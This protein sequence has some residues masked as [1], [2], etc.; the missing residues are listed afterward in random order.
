MGSSEERIFFKDRESR[1]LTVSVGWLRAYRHGGPLEDVLGKTD[2]DIFSTPHAVEAFEDEQRIILTGQPMVAKLQR[3]T[4]HDRADE[5]T[6]TTK[7]PLLSPTGEIIGTFGIARDVT[8]QVEAQQ[9]LNF[10]ALHDSVTG[11]VNRVALMDRLSQALVSL[12]SPD[13]LV[14]LFVNLDDFKS[15]NDAL[16]HG[17]GDRVLREVGRRLDRISRRGDT[18]ARL[19]ADEFVLL[20][21]A[22]REGDDLA[23]ICDRAMRAICAP[24]QDGSHDLTVTASLGAVITSDSSAEPEELLQQADVAMNVFFFIVW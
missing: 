2:F 24:L 1:F 22:A 4:F 14:L 17:T 13:R 19:G 20:C 18:V 23:L 8:A 12:E 16:G 11:L 6:S 10:Q 15:V 7:L 5:W 9:E 21:Q 3:E